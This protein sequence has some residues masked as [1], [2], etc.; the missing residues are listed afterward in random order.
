MKIKIFR[1]MTPCKLAFVLLITLKLLR[2]GENYLP[3]NSMQCFK[4]LNFSLLAYVNT[5]TRFGM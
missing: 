4:R 3:I 5:E 1:D 2:N